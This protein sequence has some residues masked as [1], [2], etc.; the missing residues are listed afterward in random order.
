LTLSDEAD[1]GDYI[2]REVIIYEKLKTG[3]DVD[4]YGD[5]KA[6][7]K[8]PSRLTHGDKKEDVHRGT[9]YVYVTNG[10]KRIR[11]VAEFTVIH[12]GIELGTGEG[13]VGTKVE[14]TGV[15]FGKRE[16]I[17]IEYDGEDV[18]N[19]IVS[20]YYDETDRYGKFTSAILIPES[21]AGEHTITV[22]DETGSQASASFT[23]EPQIAISLNEGGAGDTVEVTGTGFGGEQDVDVTLD[24][25]GVTTTPASVETNSVGSFTASFVVPDVAEGSY[26][27]TVKDEDGNKDKAE[28]TVYIA[29][30][31]SISPVTSQDSPGHVGMNITVSGV[32]FEPNHEITITYAT[33]PIVIGSTVSDDTGAF[34]HTIT[35]SDGTNTLATTFIMESTPPPIPELLLPEAEVKAIQPVRFDWEDVTDKSLPVTYTL[36]VAIDDDFT[37]ASIVREQKGLTDSEYTVT[38]EEKLEPRK[39]EAPYYWRVKATDSASNESQWS[40]PG[41]FYVGGFRW[42]S[43]IIYLWWG[44][45]ATG[46]IFFGYWLGKRRAAYYY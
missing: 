36:Q 33:E 10:S 41:S 31:V 11:A 15:D 32:G 3:Y 28:F 26:D 8:V 21:I 46:A 20:G 45:G 42:P 22:T 24:G 35:A 30:K 2:D 40:A 39:K 29:T 18:T 43:R 4:E 27:I 5:F 13:P 12:A 34:S 16:D 17:T 1:T 19:E 7:V 38:E 37:T 23:V 44:L 25:T 9:Y 14:I 6:R